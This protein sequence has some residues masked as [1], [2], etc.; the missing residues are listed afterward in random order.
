MKLP[1]NSKPQK[2]LNWSDHWYTPET[3]RVILREC[4]E[5]GYPVLDVATSPTNPMGCK[6]FYTVQGLERSW[7]HSTVFCNP[8]FSQKKRWV[9]KAVESYKEHR[10]Q[11]VMILPVS[12]M[13]NKGTRHLVNTCD[14]VGMLGRVK[15]DASP[16]LQKERISI[17]T[18]DPNPRSPMDDIGLFYWG[19]KKQTLHNRLVARN[20]PVYLTR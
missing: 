18:I 9:E 14:L 19:P 20:Y 1:T 8:P 2:P 6:Y 11:I 15:F 4:L 17:G 16:E 5:S 12:V 10:N 7:S 13:S 3:V